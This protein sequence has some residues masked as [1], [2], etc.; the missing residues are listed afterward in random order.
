MEQEQTQESA[1]EP[2][3]AIAESTAEALEFGQRL[4]DLFLEA[5]EVLLRPW[6]A[7][8]VAIAIGLYLLAALLA[9]PIGGVFHNWLRSRSGW[10]RW[11]MRVA[12]VL[13]KR[14]RAI[15][16]V[17]LIWTTVLIMQELTWPSRSWLLGVFGNLAL[18]W[19]IVGLA[20]RLVGNRLLRSLASR[21]ASSLYAGMT[22]DNA[23]S[24]DISSTSSC[25][26]RA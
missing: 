14:I 1:Q 26:G 3:D 19:L 2:K 21:C 6:N 18:A 10:P 23:C 9:R 25:A 11:R 7:Y 22:I 24:D 8:Q 4:A 17:V 13:H 16:F 12:L 5:G 15:L 20:T